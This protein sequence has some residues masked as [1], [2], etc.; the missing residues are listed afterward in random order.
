M[1]FSSPYFI[2]I[3][4]PAA[5]LLCLPW[6]GGAFRWIVFFT[7]LFFYFWSSGRNVFLLLA[8]IVLNFIGGRIVERA[9]N[10]TAFVALVVANVAIL[11]WFKY[12]GFALS[13]F[14]TVFGTGVA[15]SVHHVVLPAGISFFVFQGISYLTDIRRREIKADRSFS[16][17]GAY[18]AFF[19]HLI[20]GP[21]V[22]YRD[23]I[24]DF[25][26]P[27]SFLRLA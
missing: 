15:S 3:F 10:R 8:V 17:Y 7:S 13:S 9:A 6:R 4:L 18:Q 14:D 20:A 11:F 16:L 23:V 24:G 19:P 26:A 12:L 27:A 25:L 22:R 5:L 1:V 21:I 2:F